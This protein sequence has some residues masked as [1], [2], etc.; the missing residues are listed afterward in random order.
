MLFKSF[1]DCLYV[2]FPLLFW[3]FFLVLS[4]C[5]VLFTIPIKKH[6]T[7]S[8]GVIKRMRLWIH[9]PYVPLDLSD[10]TEAKPCIIHNA[11]SGMKFVVARGLLIRKFLK[12]A[13]SDWSKSSSSVVIDNGTEVIGN[14]KASSMMVPKVWQSYF[15]IS[16]ALPHLLIYLIPVFDLFFLLGCR[17]LLAL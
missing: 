6:S 7:T 17:T 15:R 8:G 4:S 9:S 16:S 14:W 1:F 3:G 5:Y 11:F 2:F 12:E 13:F 10:C